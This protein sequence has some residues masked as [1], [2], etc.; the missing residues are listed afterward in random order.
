MSK[1]MTTDASKIHLKHRL[2]EQVTNLQKYEELDSQEYPGWT[3]CLSAV[4]KTYGVCPFLNVYDKDCKEQR[5]P[6]LRKQHDEGKTYDD[7]VRE[8][9]DEQSLENIE[10]EMNSIKEQIT[11][12]VREVFEDLVLPDDLTH[13]LLIE[14]IR[15]KKEAKSQNKKVKETWNQTLRTMD[16]VMLKK[17]VDFSKYV[18]AVYGLVLRYKAP[19]LTDGHTNV[20]S[21]FLQL[22]DTFINLG[23]KLTNLRAN[24]ENERTD[25]DIQLSNLI[26]KDFKMD[27]VGRYFKKWASLTPDKKEERVKS[28]CEWFMRQ[29]NRPMSYSEVMKDWIMGKLATKELR[30]MDIKWDSKLGIITYVNLT[31]DEEGNFELGKRAPKILKHRKS[32]KRKRD[33]LFKSEKE[34]LL[35]QRINRLVLFEIVNSSVLNKELVVKSVL[36]NVHTR[37]IPENQLTDY[38]SSKYEE[39]LTVIREHNVNRI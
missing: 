15:L 8:L 38:I 17:G 29:S 31:M 9:L 39:M 4:V 21:K 27:Q 26:A 35:A 28:Y 3:F 7:A 16:F 30:I 2:E 24:R 18:H 5:V 33:E 11:L 12:H 20:D 13:D 32:S 34:M 22:Y 19:L 37:L 10:K 14:N 6:W 23:N 36:N 1:L 25:A